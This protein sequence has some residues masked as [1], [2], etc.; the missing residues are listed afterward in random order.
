MGEPKTYFEAD[1][2][3]DIPSIRD[4]PYSIQF[5]NYD[6]E[7][8]PYLRYINA[9]MNI[10]PADHFEKTLRQFMYGDFLL[11]INRIYI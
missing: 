8:N 7:E 1:W 10:Y 6:G 2:S 5:Y 4:L 9:E 3:S 11:T